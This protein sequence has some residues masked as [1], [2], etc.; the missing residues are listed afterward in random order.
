M[1]QSPRRPNVARLRIRFPPWVGSEEFHRSHASNLIRKV[2]AF[3]GPRFP[4]VPP[5]LPYIWPV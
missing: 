4:E 1:G 2:P 3:Y 5:D